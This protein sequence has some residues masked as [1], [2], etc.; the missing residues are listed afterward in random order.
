M[1]DLRDQVSESAPWPAR[2]RCGLIATSATISAREVRELV[3]VVALVLV[4]MSVDAGR[5]EATH[6][7]AELAEPTED[8]AVIVDGQIDV[9][10]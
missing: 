2:L 3:V 6:G 4:A 8:G 7:C 1:V 10:D 9:I 5:R